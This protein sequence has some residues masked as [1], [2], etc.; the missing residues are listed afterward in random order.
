MDRIKG[1]A[2]AAARPRGLA[3]D[4]HTLKAGSTA[5]VEELRQFVRQLR[6]KDPQQMLGIVA[7]SGLVMGVVQATIVT[8]AVIGIFTI[9]PYMFYKAE[10]AAAVTQAA[11]DGASPAKQAV[12]SPKSQPA[13]STPAAEPSATVSND[14]SKS[15]PTDG[16]DKGKAIEK[17]NMSEAKKADPN[18][19]PLENKADDLLKDLK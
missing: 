10:P 5:S 13:T 15:A 9:G 8:I 19:N 14:K 6:G 4:I 12:E 3:G 11:P 18:A 7:Q 16:I 1:N 17:M 2:E